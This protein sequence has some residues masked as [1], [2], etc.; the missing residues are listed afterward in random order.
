MDNWNR[1]TFDKKEREKAEKTRQKA[2]QK[3]KE[4]GMRPK[5]LKKGEGE[6]TRKYKQ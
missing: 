6:F 1:K 5:M 2:I 4:I 3:D